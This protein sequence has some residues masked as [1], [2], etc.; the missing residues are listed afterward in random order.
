MFQVCWKGSRLHEV[1]ERINLYYFFKLYIELKYR[2]ID[3]E[4]NVSDKCD[5]G[6][7]QL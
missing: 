2:R 4:A 1:I 5:S 3:E 7:F 6:D